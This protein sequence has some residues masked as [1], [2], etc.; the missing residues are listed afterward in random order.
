[1]SLAGSLFDNNRAVED[2]LAAFGRLDCAIGNAG[3]WDYSTNL[4]DLPA[5]KIDRAFDEVFHNNVKGY[6]LL[7][8]GLA[9]PPVS[10][11]CSAGGN[12]RR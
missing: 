9:A 7:A 12:Q 3:I 2:C 8:S 4:L 10:G 5:D 1:M 6:L 11:H